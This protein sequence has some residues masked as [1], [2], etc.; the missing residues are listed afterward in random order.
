MGEDIGGKNWFNECVRRGL[1]NGEGV[2]FWKHQCI[3]N[4]PLFHTFSSLLADCIEEDR[5]VASL[6][7]WLIER[8][9]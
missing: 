3:G 6:G 5:S 7:F 1:G 4:Q 2:N 8:W 9:I